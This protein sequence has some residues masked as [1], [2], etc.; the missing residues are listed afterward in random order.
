M[1]ST[2]IFHRDELDL[3]VELACSLDEKPGSNWVQDA[4]GLPEYICEIARA[5]KRT[6]K[7]TSR[8]IAIAVSRV[9]KW[10]AG[11]DDVNADTR[12]KA[13]KALA[14]WEAL[15]VKSKAKSKAKDAVKATHTSRDILCLAAVDFNV[16]TVRQAFDQQSREARAEWRKT[17][18]N[19][20]YEDGPPYFYIQ[21]QWTN[22]LI[23]SRD[24]YSPR[25]P[26][27]LYKIGYTV[28]TDQNVTFADPVEVKTEYVVVKD[29]DL[30][31]VDDSTL[32]QLMAASRD[33]SCAP[34]TLDRIALAAAKPTALERIVTIA[35]G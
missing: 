26:R 32:Q 34:T 25:R 23:V 3:V 7:T 30:S 11:A 15:K 17:N 16:D 2:T 5:V 19:A 10:A 4:G 24:S 20:N 1:G 9:K 21:E 8:A 31:D 27:P 22:Y 35:G 29:D 33:D 18:P 13:A 14:Q 12:A 28:D 6:G